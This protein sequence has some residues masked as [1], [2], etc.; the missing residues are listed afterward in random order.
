MVLIMNEKE[1]Y[2]LGIKEL[3]E[4]NAWDKKWLQYYVDRAYSVW[5]IGNIESY[6]AGQS[7]RK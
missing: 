3:D 5:V 4:L 7:D 6:N 2:S 1:N